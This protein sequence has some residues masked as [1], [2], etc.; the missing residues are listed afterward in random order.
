M[1]RMK[2]IDSEK[3]YRLDNMLASAQR[4]VIV[5]H[6]KPDGD[7][8]GSSIGMYHAL[9]L[10]GKSAKVAVANPVPSNLTFLLDGVE[11]VFIHENMKEETESAILGSDMI[12]CLDFNAFHRTDGLEKPL[13]EAKGRKILIDHHLNP[14]RELFDL[15]FSETEVSSASELV[16]HVLMHTS[17]VKGDASRLGKECAEAIMTG[18]TTDT[19]NFANSVFPSTLQMASG[20]LSAGVDREMILDRVYNQYG[21]NRLRLLGHMMKDLLRITSDGVAYI[22]LDRKTM[23]LYNIAEGDTEGFVNMP[24]SIAQ[25]RMS[26][27]IKEDEDSLIVEKNGRLSKVNVKT[28]P[29]P[30]FP[31]DMQ[32]QMCALQVT[33]QGTS[34]LIEGV[35]ENRFRYTEELRKMGAQISVEGRAATIVGVDHLNA[36]RVK[37]TDLRAGVAMIIAALGAEGRSEIVDIHHIERGYEDI[38]ATTDAVK[39]EVALLNKTLPG[40]KQIR[41]IEIRQTEFVK[42]T[43]KKIKRHKVNEN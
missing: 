13:A 28:L 32:P 29:Y 21:E 2:S 25:V 43:T 31:T 15:S 42:T 23:N 36:A 37:A 17:A 16:Y 26:I 34:M 33:A 10:Y 22:V 5:T 9:R 1:T 35:W 19:N 38:N 41:G 7:A 18:M 14:S 40:F 8:I 39:R 6:M 30:G 24:L 12:I 4:I 3:I 11:D 20:L 27:L